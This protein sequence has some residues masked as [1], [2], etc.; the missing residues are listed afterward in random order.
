MENPIPIQ[1]IYYLLCYAWNKLEEKDIVEVESLKSTQ[2]VDLFAKVLIGGTLHLIRRGFDRGYLHFSED[3]RLP[4]GKIDFAS[5][6][7]RNL[8]TNCRIHCEFDELSYNVLHNRI[9]KTIIVELIATDGLDS[10]LRDSLRDIER[11]LREID[12]IKL[13]PQVFRRVQLHRNNH[14]YGFLIN[15]CRLVYD[16]LLIS[17]ESGKNKFR[18]FT[19]D[20]A[21]MA[22]LFEAFVRS[23]YLLEQRAFKVQ[24]LKIEWDAE[25]ETEEG[26]LAL[27]QMR[28][29]VCLIGHTRKIILDCKY[30]KE[31]LQTNWGKRTVRSAHLYQLFAYLRNKDRELGWDQ[32]EGILL[33]PAVDMPLNHCYRI[34]GHRVSIRTI[35][36]NQDW[37]SIHNDMLAVISA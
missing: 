31:A 23:F 36:L 27:P 29:D 18:D 25:C 2:L 14:Y 28:T 21:S 4:R 17:E 3:T 10:T 35:N 26:R 5:T 24:G 13:S 7:K 20:E 15:V 34:Q 6:M 12:A 37:P 11:R 33:Y 1:N 30:Y 32:C 19:R 9:L 22:R 16:N 8:L